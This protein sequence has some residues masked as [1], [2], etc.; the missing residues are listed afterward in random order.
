MIGLP[1]E[2]DTDLE[3]LCDL[4]LQ[5][6]KEAKPSRSSVN[7]SISTFVPKPMTPFQWAPQIPL[8]E[9][10][11][12]LEF[13]KERLKKPGLRVKWH[14]PQQSVLEAVL[15][16]GDRRLGAVITRAWRLGARFDGWTEQ[17]RA[18]LWQQAFEE[19]ALD[20]AFYAQ[21]PRDEAELLPWDHL[22]AGVERDFLRKEWHKAVAGEAT[23]DCRW[24]SCTRCGVC[25]HKTVQPVLYREE[26]GGVLEAPPAAVRRSGRS[27]PTLLRLVYE[28]TG[29]AR[30]YGQLEI[31]RCFERAIRRAGL[32][33]AYSAG[34]HPHVKLSFVQALPLGMESEVEEVYLTLV[35]PRPAAAVF[36]ALNRQLPPGLRLRHAMCVPRRQPVPPRRLVRY[37]VSHLTALAVQSIVQN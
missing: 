7:V 4:C 37:Q 8:E 16:R 15:A 30:Y 1:T 36:D 12:R 13:I 25:D 24:E 22:S 32:P 26:P 21:R 28:K 29:R 17:F 6:W 27:Q 14:D 20:P 19:A 2:T 5:V 18:E 33:A 31:S 11:R 3:A 35:E 10:R 23:G 34:Y 9:V